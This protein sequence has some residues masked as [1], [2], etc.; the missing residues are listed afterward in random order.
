MKYGIDWAKI[1]GAPSI[2]KFDI[3]SNSKSAPSSPAVTYDLNQ[4]YYFR[5]GV[6]CY[7][8]DKALQLARDYLK[9]YYEDYVFFQDDAYSSDDAT[10]VLLMGDITESDGS[11]YMN[12]VREIYFKFHTSVISYDSDGSG[13]LNFP[14]LVDGSSTP[15]SVSKSF[16]FSYDSSDLLSTLSLYYGD[17]NDNS[18][19]ISSNETQLVYSSFDG[20]PHLIEGVENYAFTA[21]ILAAAVIT[22]NLID[23]VFRRVY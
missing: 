2:E 14:V 12:D 15:A 23:R 10:Y 8:T 17:I 6:D 3:S 20:Y 7:C 22:F 4:S 13:A 19:L 18:F 11:F 9:G 21:F 5:S 1:S 16:S